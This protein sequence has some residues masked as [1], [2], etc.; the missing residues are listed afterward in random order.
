M[1]NWYYAV[2]RQQHGPVP[3]E[4]LRDLLTQGAVAP[5]CLVWS[6]GMAEWQKAS[7]IEALFAARPPPVPPPPPPAAPLRRDPALLE[8][9]EDFR[10]GQV[11]RDTLTAL[12]TRLGTFLLISL[13]PHLLSVVFLGLFG[14]SIYV[15]VGDMGRFLILM[16]V[17]LLVGVPVVLF[18]YMFALGAIAYSAFQNFCGRTVRFGE[19]MRQSLRRVLPLVGMTLLV[20]AALIAAAAIKDG[21]EKLPFPWLAVLFLGVPGAII[22]VMLFVSL[23]ACMVEKTGPIA[24]MVRSAS[25]TKGYRWKIFGINLLAALAISISSIVVFALNWSITVGASR[26]GLTMVSLL[27][28]LFG[29]VL[30]TVIGLAT[31]ALMGV[32]PAVTYA[33]LRRAKEGITVHEIA[34]VFD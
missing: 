7:Q 3:E 24:S 18:V 30:V 22:G 26:L 17:V 21:A 2:E 14:W 28:R 33:N 5:D 10:I 16:A 32:V 13:V 15:S 20:F 29:F 6:D 23:P 11:F 8:G 31:T 27:V 12:K 1:T 19:A 34:R 4:Q 25:L 9:T